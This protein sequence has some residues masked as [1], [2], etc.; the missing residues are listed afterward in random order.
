VQV[1]V[2][3][4]EPHVARPGAT[5]DRV[6]VGAVVVEERAG[7]VE[8]RGDLLDALVEEPERRRI[9]EHEARRSLVHLSA[10][11]GEVEI[12]P[13]VCPH[14]L[15]LVARHRH[16]RG[17]R[18]VG[19][20]GGD[21]C[22]A[23]LPTVGEVGA[24]EH[25]A[26][27]LP[28]RAG[29]GLQR[30]RRKPRDFR[31]DL[32]QL[33]HELERALRAVVVLVRVEIA[34]TG[35]PSDTLVHPRVVLHRAAAERIEA[36]VHAE[37]PVRERGDVAHQLGLRELGKSRG[38]RATKVVGKLRPRQAVAGR[39]S[40]TATGPRPLE[41]ERRVPPRP[42]GLAHRQTSARTSA[43]RS[44]SAGVRRSVTATSRTSSMPS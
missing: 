35:Q 38:T 8:D 29:G 5:D 30:H 22:V 1:V 21:D 26:G 39:S 15:E 23:L 42:P 7:V 37:R 27:Q 11:V 19:G 14:A 31:E 2:D 3:D 4:V 9:R 25:E 17:I 34:E 20:V 43:R 33:P 36:R 28:L 10:Q 16:A 32:L 44:T 41:D 6:Q 13:S 12:A 18:A 24:H 40:R